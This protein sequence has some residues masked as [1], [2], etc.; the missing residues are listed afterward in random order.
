LESSVNGVHCYFSMITLSGQRSQPTSS[1]VVMPSS[2]HHH[3]SHPCPDD[4]VLRRSRVR[5]GAFLST[6]AVLAAVI[7]PTGAIPGTPGASSPG[8]A[9]PPS[10]EDLGKDGSVLRTSET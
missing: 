3:W 7:A 2:F 4:S 5:F 1:K 10:D 6:L 8:F 9:A